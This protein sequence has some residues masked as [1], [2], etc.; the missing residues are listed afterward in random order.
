MAYEIL[1]NLIGSLLLY[2][3]LILRWFAFYGT[4]EQLILYWYTFYGIFD[5]FVSKLCSQMLYLSHTVAQHV[6]AVMIW[7]LCFHS[8][9]YVNH[10]VMCKLFLPSFIYFF[11]I[12]ARLVSSRKFVIWVCAYMRNKYQQ[13]GVGLGPLHELVG[14]E[15]NWIDFTNTKDWRNIYTTVVGRKWWWVLKLFLLSTVITFV[16]TTLTRLCKVG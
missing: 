13:D 4:F 16:T 10:T 11:T 5:G 9:N 14:L 8:W 1:L 2:S 15:F 3:E 7:A 12:H 6:A